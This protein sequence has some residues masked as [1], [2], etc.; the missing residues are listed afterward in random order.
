MMKELTVPIKGMHCHSCELTLEDALRQL[1]DVNNASVSLRA[2]TAI[3]KVKR[4]PPADTIRKVVQGAGYDIGYDQKPWL[5]HNRADYE[6]VVYGIAVIVGIAVIFTALHVSNWTLFNSA[7]KAQGFTA[8]LVGLTA[9]VSTCMALVGGLVL[10]ISARHAEQRPE[11]TAKDRFRPHLLFNL[12]RFISFV[13]LGGVIGTLGMFISLKG[14]LL[15]LLTIG[16]GIVMLVLGVQLTDI[17]PRL[18]SSGFTLPKSLAERLGIMRRS[19]Q[20][21]SDHNALVLGALSFFL[22]CG[23]TQAMQLLAISTGSF[24]K[25][26][27]IMG[28]FALGTTP[29]L[30]AVGG[31][32]SSVTGAFAKRFFKVAGVVVLVMALYNI[33]NGYTLTGWAR[34][35]S[36]PEQTAQKTLILPGEPRAFSPKVSNATNNELKTT[37]HFQSDIIPNTFTVKA[38]STYTLLVDAKEDGSGCMSTIMIPGLVDTPQFIKGGATNRLT[39]T[40]NNPGT[41]KIT[42]AMGIQRGSINVI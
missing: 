18:S 36:H 34:P 35:F 21:Y 29:G 25:G 26:A 20:A 16:V 9:G 31:L 15:G 32:T 37:F 38:G 17:F 27:L 22:P 13:I 39:F 3:L 11:S 6:N 4:T 19:S 33:N 14:P 23:F 42:C 2:R 24:T 12:G 7:G 8:L 41:Y 40:V 5:S 1:P 10:G 30:L 28:A